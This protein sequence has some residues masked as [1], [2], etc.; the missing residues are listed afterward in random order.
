MAG[1]VPFRLLPGYFQRKTLSEVSRVLFS[2]RKTVPRVV[3]PAAAVA[4]ACSLLTGCPATESGPVPARFQVH[5]IQTGGGPVLVRF[6]SATG[7]LAQAPLAGSQR[8][9][10]IGRPTG[11]TGGEARPGRYTFDYAQAP[12]TPLTFIRV[13]TQNGTVWRLAYLRERSWTVLL[14]DSSVSQSQGEGPVPRSKP[15]RTAA[16]TA[17][18]QDPKPSEPR[19]GRRKEDID[20]FVEAVT[21][22]GLPA[23][24]RSWAVEQLGNGPAKDAAGPLIDLVH[25]EDPAIA[26]AAVR[27]LARL[28]DDRVQPALEALREDDR[29]QIRRIAAQAL[30]QRR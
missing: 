29:P 26:R 30:A 28:D 1:W 14:D 9:Q 3:R 22:P 16:R 20:A 21:S 19:P 2:T 18:Q 6:D 25:D 27:A 7:E 23:E 15:K 10:P 5:A 4:A 12:S 11:S 13:D 8:W 17:A 24:M